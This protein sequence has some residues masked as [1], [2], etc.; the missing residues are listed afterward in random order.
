MVSESEFEDDGT[1]HV[2]LPQ[3]IVSRGNMEDGKS[4]IRLTELGPR[5]TLQLIKVEDGLLDGA[6]LYHDY[7][8]KSEEE[9]AEIERKRAVKRKLKEKRKKV[10]ELNKKRKEEEK[11]K[12]KQKSL[13]GMKKA[14]SADSEKTTDEV[15]NEPE[16]DDA[17]YYRQEVGEEPDK[18]MDYRCRICDLNVF[19]LD[20]F[21]KPRT[22]QKR[23]AGAPFKRFKN[24]KAKMDG[25]NKN[26]FSYKDGKKFGNNSKAARN[27]GKFKG[28]GGRDKTNSHLRDRRSIGKVYR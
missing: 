27:K 1:T 12:L 7:I 20:L 23:S 10:Q 21:D 24:K 6:V 22:G 4:A 8:E 13:E 9:K 28:K 11:E 18:G 16:D 26:K 14:A 15:P 2:T 17:E 25:D 3:K 19:F 5:L